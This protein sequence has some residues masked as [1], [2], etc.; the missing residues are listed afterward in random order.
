MIKFTRTVKCEKKI[1]IAMVFLCMTYTESF[2]RKIFSRTVFE[3]HML[4][5]VL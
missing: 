4:H 5:H 2:A 1:K 3:S